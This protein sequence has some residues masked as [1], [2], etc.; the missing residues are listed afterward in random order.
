MAGIRG[1]ITRATGGRRITVYF[2]DAL[3]VFEQDG[4]LHFTPG[5]GEVEFNMAIGPEDG[6]FYWMMYALYLQG[7]SQP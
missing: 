7:M 5:R 6:P 4:R 2:S 3:A 1:Q